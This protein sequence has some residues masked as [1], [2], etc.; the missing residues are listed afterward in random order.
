MIYI[1]KIT[2]IDNNEATVYCEDID[3][4]IQCSILQI[5][6]N[7]GDK[8][9]KQDEQVAVY[10]QDGRNLLLGAVYSNNEQ[11]NFTKLF[12]QIVDILT[13]MKVSTSQGP[14]GTPLPEVV[15]K[16]NQ[17]ENDFKT[18]LNVN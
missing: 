2:Q 11:P 7:N 14:S 18:F 8:I 6:G 17:L 16:I 5:L 13:S 4:E 1:G 15:E 3:T 9:L 10:I 12:T